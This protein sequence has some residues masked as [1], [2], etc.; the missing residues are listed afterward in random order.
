MPQNHG[1]MIFRK[2]RPDFLKF[3]GLV[4][5]LWVL[6]RSEIMYRDSTGSSLVRAVFA[7]SI[8]V[9]EWQPGPQNPGSTTFRKKKKKRPDFLNFVGPVTPPWVLYPSQF[10]HMVSTE[11]LLARA[12][13]TKLIKVLGWQAGA[14]K[15][16]E[17]D[18]LKKKRPFF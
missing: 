16:R 4:K 9:F 10:M 6:Y 18:F 17:H 13:F 15:S 2:K 1:S 14:P 3:I 8:K 12:V 7:L 5:P 11:P